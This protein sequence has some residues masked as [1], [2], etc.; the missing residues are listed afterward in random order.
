MT[1]RVLLPLFKV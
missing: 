1:P